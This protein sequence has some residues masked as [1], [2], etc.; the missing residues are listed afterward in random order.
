MRSTL[1]S[2]ALGALFCQTSLAL[3]AVLESRDV[4]PS[5]LATFNLF[6]QYAAA[7][8]C[9]ENNNST[10][11]KLT[12]SV[13]NCPEVEAANT[14]TV[15]EFQ[16]SLVTDVTGYV[17]VDS[18]NEL[19]VVAFRG[20]ESLRNWLSDADFPYV[21][22]N[23]CDGCLV[24]QGF[25]DSWSEAKSDI[26][27]AAKNA[28]TQYPNYQIVVTGHSL[29]AAIATFAAAEL[30]IDGYTAA[31]Y[32]FGSPRVGNLK[33]TELI[34]NQT[35]GNYRITH[36]DD[37]VPKLPPDLI[38]YTHISPEYW[39]TTGNSI[40]VADNDISLCYGDDNNTCNG[41]TAVGLDIAAHKWYFGPIDSCY[42]L[43]IEI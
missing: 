31:L 22:S 15:I 40:P 13:G 41:G 7:S 35:G 33:T 10:G 36:F 20:S 19:I 30:R 24:D 18:T 37:P 11:S 34:G 12:C 27:S 26:L 38:G 29:G 39:I 1:F 43:Q 6:E 14:Y 28:S 32:N 16:N 9:T 17:A 3:P 25:W 4:S 2:V 42:P 21:A 5:L 23:L 8:Y